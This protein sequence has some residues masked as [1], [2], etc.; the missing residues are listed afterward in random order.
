MRSISTRISG[1]MTIAKNTIIVGG[2]HAGVNLACMLELERPNEDY[3]L[4]ERATSL[5]PK[6]RESRWQGFQL[7]T[8]VKYGRLYGQTNDK[9]HRED[10]LLD[11]PIQEDIEYWDDHIKNMGICHKLQTNVLQVTKEDT[12]DADGLFHVLV[13][14]GSTGEQVQYTGKN[15][16]VC[17]GMFDKPKTPGNLQE[18]LAA[19][20]STIKSHLPAGFEFKNLQP[21]N[22]LI[23][24]SGQTGVQLADL[25]VEHFAN[26]NNNNSDAPKIYLCTSG[27]PGCPRTIL[28]KDLFDWLDE[29]QFLSM[30]RAALA[31]VP[32]EQAK[33]MKYATSPVTGPTKDITPFSL[34]RK[35]VVILGG[36]QSITGSESDHTVFQL[37]LNRSDNLKSCLVGHDKVKKMIEEH[38]RKINP[39]QSDISSAPE[40]SDPE[41]ELLEGT[42]PSTLSAK[43]DSITNIIWCTGW[44][45]DFTWL[46][47][48]LPAALEDMDPI[49]QHP[50]TICSPTVKG[51]FYLGFPWI[52]TLQSANLVKFDHDANVV[53]EHLK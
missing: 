41:V 42:G 40:W 37:K 30:P 48:H 32:P 13:E 45:N 11:R 34:H 53:M 16:V 44:S 33:A 9:A 17:N 21:G 29:M 7:N 27:V 52:G 4:L 1:A 20:T 38:I 43:S 23:V 2:G 46:T 31:K 5:L 24:G 22:T 36:L 8:P 18:Q 25:L 49:A 3:L 51:L 28:G 12:G 50:D 19:S 35:G 47:N 6:W 39:G 26:N 10:T 15:L 14:D